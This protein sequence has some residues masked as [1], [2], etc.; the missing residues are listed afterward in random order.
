VTASGGAHREQGHRCG[1]SGRAD[2]QPGLGPRWFR[3]AV[4]RDPEE[5]EREPS[6]LLY[7]KDEQVVTPHPTH[8]TPTPR[9][10]EKGVLGPGMCPA[11]RA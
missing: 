1:R 6:R 3:R 2:G 9:A 7:S 11:G 4:G 10:E 5:D 8:A